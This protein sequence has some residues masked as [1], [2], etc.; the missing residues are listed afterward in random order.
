MDCRA[1]IQSYHGAGLHSWTTELDYRAGLRNCTT[2][3]HYGTAPRNCTTTELHYYGTAL[4]R[5]CTTELHYYGTELRRW[6]TELSGLRSWT[7]IISRQ[8]THAWECTE[9]RR[10]T[11]LDLST[12]YLNME[13]ASKSGY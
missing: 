11:E 13:M 1:R 3:L 6:D 12:N 5:N 4:L 2:E 10:A 8:S 9:L 7:T